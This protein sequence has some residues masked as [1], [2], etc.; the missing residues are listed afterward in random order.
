MLPQLGVVSTV[1]LSG[2]NCANRKS[3][4]TPGRALRETMPTLLVSGCAPP[5]PSI[6]RGRAL[7][8]TA[9]STRSRVAMSAGRSRRRK[10]APWRCRPASAGRAFRE[11][12]RRGAEARPRS[13]TTRSAKHREQPARLLRERGADLTIF[14]PRAS[15]WRITRATRR[16]RR[17][18]TQACNDLIHRVCH[19]YPDNF[20][21]VCQLPQSPGAPIANSIEELERCVEELGFVGCN[22]NPDPSGGHWTAPPLTDRSGIRSTRRWSSSTC[23]R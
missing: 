7:P 20:V 13:A 23:R 1:S 11:A 6:W 9:S 17:A 18:W 14:S 21:G 5:R 10:T 22:L 3:R 12:L 15:A 2:C 19:L 16:P 8:I 4:S